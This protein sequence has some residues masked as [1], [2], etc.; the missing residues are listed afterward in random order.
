MFLGIDTSNYKT[1]VGL[2][3]RE[4][5]VLEDLRQPLSVPLGRP[6]LRQQEAV[7]QHLNNLPKL[8]QKLDGYNIKEELQCVTAT[9]RPRP[10][11][12]SYMP[13]FKA[14]EA[15]GKTVSAVL[16]IPFLSSSHQEGHLAAAFENSSLINEKRFLT[17]HLSGGTLEMLLI[18]DG[19]TLLGGTADISFGQVLDRLGVLLGMEFPSGEELNNMALE[20]GEASSALKEIFIREGTVNL[21]GFDT[22]IQRVLKSKG[23]KESR[24]VKEVFNKIGDSIISLSS[25]YSQQ[26]KTGNVLMTGGVS[27]SS[28]LRKYI[29]E[30]SCGKNMTFEFAK[31]HMSSDNGVGAAYLG[32]RLLWNKDPYPFQTLTDI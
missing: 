13:C 30:R 15:F 16:K 11:K 9:I 28:Y 19:I 5:K 29:E 3:D 8:F 12:D 31:S 21:S 27:A 32:R 22:Q 4:G 24:V 17:F 25:Y 26:T 2:I 23:I 14:G 7:F 6:G 1:S 18:E 10:V 20:E